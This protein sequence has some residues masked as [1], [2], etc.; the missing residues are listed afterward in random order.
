MDISIRLSERTAVVTGACSSLGRAICQKLTE[1]GA[2]VLIADLNGKSGER[3]AEDLMNQREVHEKRGRAVFLHT[4][5]QNHQ[6]VSDTVIRGAE[7]F[8]GV[9][10]LVDLF[11][12]D[13]KSFESAQ[14]L[15]ERALPFFTSRKRGK[16]LFF[17]SELVHPEDQDFQKWMED[18][19]KANLTLPI[20]FNILRV[21]ATEEYLLKTYPQKNIQQALT[22]CYPQVDS[23]RL[24]DSSQIA[25]TVS[26]LSSPWGNAING[27][28][29]S[30]SGGLR[31]L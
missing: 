27:E 29:L 21:G 28:S 11:T 24:A 9:D 30:L 5:P 23:L 19:A 26:F 7:T 4:D 14:W 18:K 16:T 20:N 10:I 31:L 2:S 13:T 15:T 1:C 6:Q 3:L 22:E 25:S 12:L 17:R 8:G